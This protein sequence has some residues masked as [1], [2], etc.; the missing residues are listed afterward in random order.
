MSTDK[1]IS[2]SK[3]ATSNLFD[4]AISSLLSK[5]P[6][7]GAALLIIVFSARPLKA[8]FYAGAMGGIS[9][10]S[11][12]TQAIINSA[13]TDFATYNP[14][15]G[16]LLNGLA[17]RH[18]ND[19]FTIQGDYVWNRNSLSLTAATFAPGSIEEYEESRHSS[20]QSLFASVLVYFRKRT[21]WVRPYLS[22]GTGWVHLSST[23]EVITEMQGSP[24]LPPRQFSANMIA[25]RVPVGIDVTLHE[26]WRFRYSFSENISKNPIS[27]ELSSPGT[28]RLKNFQNLFGMVREF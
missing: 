13:S 16:P 19:I 15:N 23:E 21:S 12:N 22:V 8:Q 24:V 4:E 27:T 18:L 10:L 25:L 7:L 11:G 1:D 5:L 6:I 3:F 14:Q 2:P 26:G 9:T 20:Q 28:S 17:G